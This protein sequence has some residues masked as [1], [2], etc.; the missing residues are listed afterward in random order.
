MLGY[1][2]Q[3]DFTKDIS[4]GEFMKIKPITLKEIQSIDRNE[5]L[6]S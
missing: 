2:N 4:I 6:L 1:F 5:H 3:H